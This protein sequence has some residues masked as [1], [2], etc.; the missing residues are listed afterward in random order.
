M[1]QILVNEKATRDSKVINAVDTF[2]HRRQRRAS[3]IIARAA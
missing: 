3:R 1:F 2:S